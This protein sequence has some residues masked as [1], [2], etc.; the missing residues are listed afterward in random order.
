MVEVH[1][2]AECGIEF[3]AIGLEDRGAGVREEVAVLGID[4]NGDPLGVG[5][6]D[7]VRDHGDNEHAL[8]VVL[9]DQRVGVGHG[10]VDGG[11]QGLDLDARAI[12]VDFF[13]HANELLRPREDAGLGRGRTPGVHEAARLAAECAEHL[14][15]P[16]AGRVV[17]HDGDHLHLRPDGCDVLG[18]VGRSAQ[19]VLALAHADYGDW[20]LGGHAID[21]TMEIDVEHGVTDDGDAQGGGFREE[22][23]ETGAKHVGSRVRV[24]DV[25]TRLKCDRHARGTPYC[26][27]LYFVLALALLGISTSGPL[28]RLSASPPLA[29]A[30]WRLGFSLLIVAVPLLITGGWRQWRTLQRKDFAIAM[31]AGAFLAVHFWSWIASLGMTSVAASVLLVNLHPVAMIAGS[32]LWLGERPTRR[33]IGGT[34]IGLCGAV[35]IAGGDLMGLGSVVGSGLGVQAGG[36]GGAGVIAGDALALL[37]ALTVSFYYLSARRLRSKLDVWPYVALVYGSCFVVLLVFSAVQGV[38]LAPQPPRELMIFAAI[39]L[40]PMLLGHT[41]FNWALKHVSAPTVSLVMLGEPVGATLIAMAV[42]A[43]REVP[44]VRTLIGGAVILT[45]IVIAT[46]APRT[47]SAR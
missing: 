47:P 32:A 31:A 13:I 35:V 39:A 46:L 6:R 7:G 25:A 19:G 29:I 18:H 44:S 4:D 16:R 42:P 2:G 36:T 15:Q 14:P 20:R 30:T 33:Q 12:G 8:V 23:F 45:G 9:E 40:G 17:A 5:A 26:R 43:I 24:G 3:A 37:G 10:A 27:V 21:V 1:G 28:A 34:A 41:G 38:A 22:L 11:Q